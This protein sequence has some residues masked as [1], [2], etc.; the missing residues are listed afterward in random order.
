MIGFAEIGV[1]GWTPPGSTI[2]RPESV[3][4]LV[5]R[6]EWV[7]NTTVPVPVSHHHGNALLLRGLAVRF[8]V[9]LFHSQASG[10]DEI[11]VRN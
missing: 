1:V 11:E 2:G 9:S 3:S 7:I 10:T 6:S 8:L 5:F 4:K